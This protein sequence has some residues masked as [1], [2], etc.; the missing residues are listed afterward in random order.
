[1][2]PKAWLI[3]EN[4]KNHKQ[5]KII[6]VTHYISVKKGHIES[7]IVY[8]VKYAF[9][10]HFQ[11]RACGRHRIPDPSPCIARPW[12]QTGSW[13]NKSSYSWRY[14][15]QDGEHTALYEQV[16]YWAMLSGGTGMQVATLEPVLEKSGTVNHKCIIF[17]HEKRWVLGVYYVQ[18]VK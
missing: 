14:T 18:N 3:R 8:R 10:T 17:F 6:T 15:Y 13:T 2:P 16:N 12:T 11:C 7:L 1:M 9:E 4:L 5:Q